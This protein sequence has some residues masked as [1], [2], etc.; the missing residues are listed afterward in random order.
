MK[1]LISNLI[2][3]ISAM[4]LSACSEIVDPSEMKESHLLEGEWRATEFS[5]RA[6]D[7]DNQYVNGFNLSDVDAVEM[8]VNEKGQYSS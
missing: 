1:Y 6:V 7:N 3:V 5:L 4:L 2:I 8:R